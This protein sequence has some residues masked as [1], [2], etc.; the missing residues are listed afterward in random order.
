MYSLS[1]VP[2]GSVL[3]ACLTSVYTMFL[4]NNNTDFASYADDNTPYWPDRSTI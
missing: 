4:F 2:Q 3:G 1:G